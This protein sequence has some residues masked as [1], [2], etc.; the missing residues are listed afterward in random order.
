MDCAVCQH[1][2]TP[3]SRFFI[4]SGTKRQGEGAPTPLRR[5]NPLAFLPCQRQVLLELFELIGPNEW[6]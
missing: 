5:L 6:D 2:I 3:D 1:D 4:R